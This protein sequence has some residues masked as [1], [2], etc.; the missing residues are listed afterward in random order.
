MP[1]MRNHLILFFITLFSINIYAAGISVQLESD[2]AVY[3]N[4][5]YI[6]YTLT[7][8]NLTEETVD[9]DSISADFSSF[10][11]IDI[12][13]SHDFHILGSHSTLG[14]YNPDGDSGKLQVS[15]ATIHAA[16]YLVYNIRALVPNDVITDIV[17]PQASVITTTETVASNP[18]TV[19]PAPYEYS[20]SL[21][22]D[23][24]EYLV[25]GQLTYTL[26]AENT[27]SYQVQNLNIAQVF[28]SSVN[29]IEGNPQAPFSAILN[30]VK[31]DG[32]TTETGTFSTNGALVANGVKIDVGGKVV[33][34]ML[35]TLTDKLTEDIVASASA[36]TKDGTI[37]S[38]ELTTPPAVGYLEITR[39]EFDNTSAYLVNDTMQIHLT[40]ENT[41][42]GIVYK[43]GVQNNI[44]DLLTNLGNDLDEGKYDHSDVTGHPYST[45]TLSV[46][47]IGPN[48]ISQLNNDGGAS[49]SS[50]DDTVS[51]Y[52]G[53]SVEYLISAQVSPVTIGSIKSLTAK[54]LTDEGALAS[55]TDTISTV[56]DPERVLE[57]GDSQISITKLTSQA[58]YSPG[59]NVVYDITV[60]NL[61]SSYFANNLI[62]VDKLSCIKTELA[63]GVGEGSAFDS[64]TLEVVNGSDSQGTDAGAFD[65]G[66]TKTGDLTISPDI[67]PGATVKYKLTAK[68]SDNA[69]GHILDDASCDDDIT[70]SGTGIEMPANSLSVTKD[71]D[72]YKYSAGQ[73][74][75]YTIKIANTSDATADMIPVVDELSKVMVTD[76]EG[77]SIPAYSSWEI[78]ADTDYKIDETL[79]AANTSISSDDYPVGL[80]ATLTIPPHTIVTYTIFTRLN[81]KANS[82]I[83]NEVIVDGKAI[84]DRGSVPRDFSVTASKSAQVDGSSTNYYSKPNNSVTYQI[85]VQN[86]KSNG[87]ATNVQVQ[88]SISSIQANMLE[89]D[90]TPMAVFNSWTVSAQKSVID[91]SDLTT[92]QQ[93]NLLAASDVGTFSDNTDLDTTAQ[94]APNVRV[95]YTIEAQI[96]RS[97]SNKI[98]W[99]TFTNTA[100]IST[101]DNG[102]SITR[103][104]S[105]C[106]H[107]PDV[108]VTKTTPN[109]NFT[110]GDTVV[111]DIHVFNKGS[112]Y[113]N[114]VDV[115]D[116]INALGVFE[117]GWIIT[118]V[119]D[120]HDKT[121]SYADEK[122]AW[123]DG[124][125]IVSKVDIDPKESEGEFGGMGY[126]KYTVTGVV[127]SDYTEDEISNTA[128][129]HDPLTNT[130]KSS[131]AEI[132]KNGSDAEFNVSILK[133]SDK[134]RVVPGEEI[135]YT[136]T[137]LN[138][139]E[140]VTATDLTVVD[141]MTEIKSVLA[142]DN[143]D[144]GLND[145]KTNNVAD[146]PSQSP[147]EYWKFKLPGESNF[148]PA[149]NDDFIYPAIGSSDALT[150]APKEVKQF[151]IRA[152]VKD[153]FIGIDTSGYLE[154]L[155]PNYAYVFRHYDD[156]DYRESHVS[157]HENEITSNG[158]GT[159]RQLLVN[160]VAN[161]YYSPGDKLTYTVK[162]Y[163][164]TG[165][166][167]NHEVNEDILSVD[168]LLMDGSSANPFSTLADSAAAFTVNVMKDAGNGN[169]GTTTGEYEDGA[170]I[171]DGQNIKTT[172]DVAG[173]DY[174]LYTVEGIVR[175]D[176][177][178]SITIG[179]IT[180]KPNDYHLSFYKTSDEATYQPGQEVTYHL[181]ITNDGL[182]NAY[183]IPVFDELSAIKVELVDGSDG[184]AFTTWTVNPVVTGAEDGSNPQTGIEAGYK[185]KDIDTYASIPAGATIDYQVTTTI[186]PNAVG[187]IVNVLS[188]NGD[189]TS[190]SL[191]PAAPKFNYS[192]SIIAYYDSND[193]KQDSWSGY[194]PDG[195]VEYE[196]YIGNENEVHLNDISIVDD[197]KGITTSCYDLTT[198]TTYSCAAFDSW[199]VTPE[200]DDSGITHAGLTANDSNIDTTFDLAA[201]SAA[202]VGNSY[203]K[204]TIKAHIVENAVGEFKNSVLVDGRYQAS[205]DR[206]SMLP[207]NLAKTHRA[208]TDDS[209][210]V[211]KTSYSHKVEDQK[212]VYHLRI[213]NNGNGLEYGKALVEKFSEL[214]VRIAQINDTTGDTDKA[215]TYQPK[216]WSVMAKTSDEPMTSIGSFTKTRGTN[217]DIDIPFVSIAPGGYI[218]FVME[219]EI[220]DDA[221]DDIEIAPIYGGTSFSKSTLTPIPKGLSVTKKIVSV[222]GKS[223]A[224]GDQYKPGDSVEYEFTVENT[225]TVWH[226]NTVIKDL[227][228]N[229]TVE[230]I[231]GSTESAL[232]NTNISHV[233]TDDLD[234]DIDTRT[235]SYEANGDLDI[236]V[237][238]GLDIA[239]KETIT[240]TITGNI[241]EDAVGTVDANS[242][243]GGDIA[244]TTEVIPPVAP[245]LAIVKT[246]QST[247]A[248]G[249]SCDFPSVSGSG[250]EY[251]PM[252]QVVYQVTVTNG[253]EGTAN[254]AVIKD[255]IT[256]ITT[257]DGQSAFV[258][259]NV[260]VVEQPDASRFSISGSYE[261]TSNLDATFDLMPSDTV[262]F[263]IIATVANDAQGTITNVASI[264]GTNSNE[265]I[266]QA[267]EATILAQKLSDT[268]I[269]TPGQTIT[270]TIDILND[271]DTDANVTVIDPIS[272]FMVKTADGKQQTAL[273]DGWTINTDIVTDGQKFAADSYTDVSMMPESGDI[274]ET[275]RMAAE[276]TDG[277]QTHVRITI[278]GKIRDDAIGQ[279]TNIATIDGVSYQ[280]DAG[281]LTPDEG[282]LEVTKNASK[283]P[284]ATYVPGETIG[285]DIEVKNSGA[286][287]LTDLNIVDLASDIKTDFAGQTREG[288]AISEW[289]VTNITVVGGDTSLTQPVSGSEVT[290]T[291]GF[292][293]NY[294]IAPSQ[295]INLHLEGVVDDKAMGDI[296]NTVVVT[297]ANGNISSAQATYVPEKAALTV[298]KTVDKREYE[299]G[300]TLTYTIVVT[301]TTGAWAKDVQ[302]TDMLSAIE[303]TTIDGHSQSAFNADSIAISA[304]SSTGATSIPV[305]NSGDI[306][307]TIEIAPKDTLTI[308]VKGRLNPTIHSRVTN[309]VKVELDGEE[310]VAE[311]FSDPV[312]PEVKLTKVAPVE[313]YV[314]GEVSDFV[315]TIENQTNGYAD[316]IQVEDLISGLT[317]DTIDGTTEQAFSYWVL[318]V[319]ANNANTIITSRA[320]F[321]EDIQYN[322]D[323]APLDKVIF[324]V[325]GTVNPKA[326]GVIENSA[327]MLFDSNGD[328]TANEI[329]A[330]AQLKPYEQDVSFIKTLADGT[331]EGEYKADEQTEFH[332]TLVNNAQSFAQN[333][334]IKDIVSELTV[335][336][337]LGQSVPALTS[338]DISYQI[339]N[340]TYDTTTI[341]PLP[342]GNDL[343]AVVNLAPSATIDFV[344][345]GTVNPMALGVIENT[346]TMDDGSS[347]TDSTVILK[348]GGI[349]LVV[350]KVADKAEYTNDDEQITYTLAVT[351]RGS[352]DA[353]DV[354]LVDEISKLQAANGNPLFTE[355]E[356]TIAEV[357]TATKT[358]TVL[359]TQESIDLDYT[360]TVKAY[361]GNIIA[362]TIVGQIGKGIDD[363]I[364]N[365]FVATPL[366]GDMKQDSVTVHVK[367]FADNEGELVVSKRALQ[368]SAQVGDV[369]E[370]EV[371]IENN[372]ESEFKNVHLVDRYPSG[373]QYIE[374]SAEVTNSG[375]DGEF[376]TADDVFNAED[377]SL[378]SVMSFN[379]GDMLAYGTSGSTIQE[380][381]R[382]RYLMR[383][384][385]G[386]TFG[387]YINTAFAMTP[388]EGMTSGELQIKSNLSSASVEVTP[389]KLFDTASIIGKVFEDF[390]GDGYQADATAFGVKLTVD[391][392][393]SI[394]VTHSATL[395]KAGNKKQSV[396]PVHRSLIIER[397]FGLSRNR[398]LPESNKA[399]VQFKTTTA[400]PIAFTVTTKDGT[401]ITANKDGSFVVNHIGNK[402]KGLSAENIRLTRNLY[403]D[404]DNYLREIVIENKGIYEEGIP[405][406]KLMTVEGIVIETDQYGRYHVPD[407][408]VL[409]KKGKQFLVKLDTDSLPT[410]MRVISENPKVRRIT[411]N[412]LSKFNFS[413]QSKDDE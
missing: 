304:T 378:T 245:D 193:V 171:A 52:P 387:N 208:Y 135:T 14:T 178:G 302:I 64:W 117:P 196:I 259:S 41:G 51:V 137:L 329:T 74:L 198:G 287:Y 290:G 340:D 142:N 324:T 396:T 139:S 128:Q 120:S 197:I 213:D 402:A 203:V 73:E 281:Y 9:I 84:A 312:I 280:V 297:D 341:T 321:N 401:N 404:G 303:G 356:T 32:V 351:N 264:D 382:V 158:S 190:A 108:L 232:I 189:R 96:D 413:V 170:V 45:W 68:V 28:S 161:Q 67:A 386:A 408:W 200:V 184:S 381:I 260:H 134:V 130:D 60:E 211:V 243:T 338:W 357:D 265:I 98:V 94:I 231:G 314:P 65:Y 91:S 2:K 173:G 89:P 272:A 118:S 145:N 261:G 157:H 317:V 328:G 383:V 182:G 107:D 398:T 370:Y 132:S 10:S 147:F 316:D 372:N 406:I 353:I 63:G 403:K 160:G 17:V 110:I 244:V 80:N 71:V 350:K 274:N 195:Y 86:E 55:A 392:D 400:E 374:G 362:I 162:V 348:P 345:K 342:I 293:V 239:P 36:E 253:G 115:S 174:V 143:N 116:D 58:Q 263:E 394:V 131:T 322:I 87:Y 222:G 229:I 129:I 358:I 233:I 150:L 346:A 111:F 179:G 285:F 296:T 331:Q 210:S 185:D 66:T 4:N 284:E 35:A 308:T 238:D 79:I 106:P 220:R 8:N 127:K 34:T 202:G 335:V 23:K 48:S 389:D 149:N 151:Q 85:V 125:N 53:E 25:S 13:G 226:D 122:S 326:V 262:T 327:T 352:S 214:Q 99:G 366:S 248:D 207:A 313:N 165:Y 299:A 21:T 359:E 199:T 81:P 124:G 163:S 102:E 95:T 186:N 18:V 194:Q 169:D 289:V 159:T 363:D 320:S 205:S 39:H 164:T 306:N 242:A 292:Q 57:V 217:S 5:S 412:A 269:Y 144:S 114:D 30:S 155:L 255:L 407:Q 224:S 334:N 343:D 141:L 12:S 15:G 278:T 47:S 271:S 180:V 298:S 409:N 22:V 146:Y 138:N 391:V 393:P 11:E 82:R 3:E 78:S 49:A 156:V 168:V 368:S 399:T 355:W 234:G 61:S 405:G 397:L 153:N 309:S 16:G 92:E 140:T 361:E 347:I 254:D 344:V 371:V 246:V 216:G 24:S 72:V 29:D 376:D 109:E 88:D 241:R 93:N 215:F 20:L 38:N 377:P 236:A 103:S 395:E 288:Q 390:N 228:S 166:L 176:A 181:H 77:N 365:T 240:F 251:N 311:A 209:K 256:S 50:L 75:T 33:Y 1:E 54:V 286:G 337:V 192:K 188:V 373:F 257:S 410:G 310:L 300:D 227:I 333:I 123:T 325:H 31:G 136:I 154:R 267:G 318:D 62:I 100:T 191:T 212:V 167:N 152:Q 336:N 27:G 43:Y 104:A 219:S 90:N 19:T 385:V 307:G 250:C 201:K 291:D 252:G 97:D 230:V 59:Q 295:S 172:I 105:V 223:Y 83:S 249:S 294:N 301:N 37:V 113:A 380:K 375:P 323:L 69:V 339:T 279:F 283:T 119:V 379:V 218:E 204:Y 126:V 349:E 187:E 276:N 364:T 56:L 148:G 206:S 121:G 277:T 270:Y 411:P 360:H 237:A 42:A 26:T 101:P 7:I 282:V 40:V 273:V 367:K 275:I 112:G 332:I 384:T 319:E 315:I 6:D 305:I 183:N 133:T 258:S 369:I 354:H 221:I 247:T 266:L 330:T 70:E 175:E 268:K 225:Q 388:A 44:A 46:D 177:V 76:I 235:P